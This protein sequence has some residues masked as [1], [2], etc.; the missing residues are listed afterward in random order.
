MQRRIGVLRGSGIETGIVRNGS[1]VSCGMRHAAC[2]V[3]HAHFMPNSACHQVAVS[4]A[5]QQK[6]K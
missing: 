4:H 2:G 1:G 5:S 3:R 6:M